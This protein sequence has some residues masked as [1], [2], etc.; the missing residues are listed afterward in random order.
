MSIQVEIQYAVPQDT[1]PTVED[2]QGWVQV[3]LRGQRN[4]AELVIRIVDEEEGAQLNETYRH[5]NGPTNVLSFP[6]TAP[7]EVAP[8]LLGDI[9][10]C[11]PVVEKEAAEQGKLRHAHWAHMVVHGVLHLLGYDHQTEQQAQAMEA[12]ETKVL[13]HLGYPDPY[14]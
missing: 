5:G 13:G 14:G 3:A 1:A 6:C 10:I 11:A 7:P 2:L 12:L 9:V 8:G 4:R